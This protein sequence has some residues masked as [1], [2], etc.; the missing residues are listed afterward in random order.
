MVWDSEPL[1]ESPVFPITSMLNW[2][3]LAE[4]QIPDDNYEIPETA[5]IDQ[6]HTFI[7]SKKQSGSGVL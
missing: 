3:R 4:A 7:G 2:V 6:L 1:R 5:Q